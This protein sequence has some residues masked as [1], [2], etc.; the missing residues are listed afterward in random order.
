[1]FAH[2]SRLSVLT[3]AVVLAST[4]LLT[5]PASAQTSGE[6]PATFR[7][8]PGFYQ[9]IAGQFA[10]LNPADGSYEQI[11]ADESNYNP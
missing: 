3:A 6:A 5:T 9:V 10:Q 2:R 11:G 4:T 1:M 7:C 8:D